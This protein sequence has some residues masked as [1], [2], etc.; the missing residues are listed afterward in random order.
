MHLLA[1]TPGGI[2]DGSEAVDL[3]Q[4]PGD[5]IFLSAA[6][7]ELSSLAL[8]HS[9]RENG[10][11]TLRLAN[12]M[13]LSHNLSVDIYVEEIIA[14][15][16]L[17][18]IRIL[19]GVSYWPYGTEQITECCRKNG[20]KLAFLPGDDQPDEELS[21]LNTVG[22]EETHRLWQYLV[23]GGAS[24][25]SEFLNYCYSLAGEDTEWRE[26]RPL[27]KAG[28]YWPNTENADLD[29]VQS[30]W[31]E[32]A[33]VVSIVF[34][35]A[36]FQAN[37]LGPVDDF[38]AAFKKRG[39]NALPL[40]VSSLKDPISAEI[41]ETLFEE[42]KPSV[43][44]NATGFAVSNP[45]GVRKKTPFDAADCQVL[46]VIFSGGNEQGWRDG[47]SGL[48][49]RD[50][51]MNVA[52]PEVDGRVLSRAVSFKADAGFH[53]ETQ[54]NIVAYKSVPDRVEF[55]ADLAVNWARLRQTSG[56]DRKI[57]LILANYPNK[58][59]RI[60]NGVGLDTP[61]GSIEVLKALKAEDYEV[62]DIP[63]CGND[64]VDLLLAG[65]TN[66]RSEGK[67][68]VSAHRL[69][70][71]DYLTFFKTLPPSIQND[72]QERWGEPKQDP[73]VI[74]QDFHLSIITCGNILVGIQPARGYNIDPSASYHDP[75]LVPPHGYFAFYAYLRKTQN[76]HGIVHMGK[77]GNMEWLPGKSLALSDECYPE[78]VFGPTP[79]LYPFIVNDPGEGTQAKRRAS[80][81]IIDHLT[82]PMTRAES[83]G[84][85]ADL[86][87][88]V[89]EYY[90]AAGV[91]PR[92]IALL[93]K[94][95]LE[96]TQITGV[97]VD[98]GI[99][100]DDGEDEQLSKLDNYLC[101]LK[102]LQIRDGLHIFGKSPEDRQ[103]IDLLVALVRIP[104]GDGKDGDASLIRA[105]AHDLQLG[106]EFDPLDCEMGALWD[107]PRPESLTSSSVWRSKG[108]TV[109]RL[110]E[111]AV[112]LVS[113]SKTPEENW[114]N[115]RAILDK[116]RDDLRPTVEGCGASE[117]DGLL[118]GLDGR[119]V[120]PGP[121]GAPTRGRN[122]VL[123]TGRNFYSVDSRAIPTPTA[124]LLGWKSAEML[125]KRYRQEN[126]GWPKSMILSAW[127]TSNMRTGGDDIAQA[128]A[129]MGVRP[130]WD[131]ASNRVTGFEIMS[132]SLLD[133]P[134]VD[135][136]LRISGFFRDAF[137]QQMAL[138]DSAARAIANLDEDEKTNPLA[139]K[140]MR[141]TETLIQSGASAEDARKK[142]SYRLFGSKP[143][144]YGAGLQALIDEKGWS[145]EADLARAYVAWG[146]YAYGAGE[147]GKPAHGLF[148]SRLKSIDA[149]VHNQDNREHDLLDSDDYYQF[150]GGVTAAVRHLKGSQPIVYHNDHSRPESPKIRTLEE[151]ISRVVRAR[152]ANPKWI[153]GAM[154]HGYKG[155]FEMAATVD[156][157]FAF[158]ATA[159]AVKDHHFDMLFDA[160]LGDPEVMD[161]LK[162]NNPDA[163]QE[164]IDKFEEA[165]ERGLW[166]PRRN[167]LIHDLN[168]LKPEGTHE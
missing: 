142:A 50:I 11:V 39:I 162:E 93:R 53:K 59:G 136:T 46:Q 97:D 33:P 63:E 110:E 15:A 16:K 134:R 6:D 137:P 49:P 140:V 151:E 56:K 95:I 149:V 82:P 45:G 126:G 22:R 19:G 35:R 2:S 165:L 124:W 61:A 107:G 62:E 167:S 106:D 79:H 10:S 120:A 147:E 133:R 121:S 113:N 87:R 40:Y 44:L 43:I 67:T 156:Y 152:A 145:D 100:T 23:H 4:S 20:I 84:P 1:A 116:I 166:Q 114:I 111:L 68:V 17:V 12:Y 88:L 109:E 139:A 148:E 85:L 160:Y 24:N 168:A 135:V 54:T 155:A 130:T 117:I 72:I 103:L 89:D 26:P 157:L 55:V 90:E 98:C 144:A 154:R 5:I 104:R 27:L 159:H 102:E 7:T 80:A 21:A 164:M 48:S 163:L 161:F 128:L 77:H 122:D 64:L 92:R 115:T 70:L 9:D 150:E 52:L 3:G 32:G 25:Y 81:V 143:G 158:A 125:I 127:G 42:T 14:A 38:I 112:A 94:Q 36:L 51:A 123:P 99:Q 96:L 29:A 75:D 28:L 83:Y 31:I 66:D 153:E 86:E 76:V 58:N 74:D 108:D 8:A 101:E 73:F 78:A 47:I 146:G 141:D 60:G 71:G 119:F 131:K 34:Y 30:N 118:T 65:P 37:N 18:V 41:V 132:A 105:L 138:F 129:L 13:Q 69:S 57:A 91:D